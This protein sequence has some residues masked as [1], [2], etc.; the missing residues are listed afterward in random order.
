MVPCCWLV[1]PW[2]P[3]S[4]AT[5]LVLEQKLGIVV[6]WLCVHCVCQGVS[7]VACFKAGHLWPPKDVLNV[8]GAVGPAALVGF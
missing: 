3:A 8:C 4:F 6:F 2:S 5:V 1:A 7:A